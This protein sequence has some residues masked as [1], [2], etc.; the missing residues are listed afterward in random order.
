MHRT[1]EES[2]PSRGS[3]GFS[4][5]GLDLAWCLILLALGWWLRG[6]AA[7][8]F[9]T[10]D[11]PAWVYRSVAFLTALRR[12]DWALTLQTGHPGVLTMWSGALSLAWHE[13]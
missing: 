8:A 5:W 6:T 13:K 1:K 12:G 10:W 9:V 7:S 3:T 11:E 4:R 2:P